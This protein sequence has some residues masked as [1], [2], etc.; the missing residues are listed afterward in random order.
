M[1]KVKDNLDIEKLFQDKFKDFQMDVNPDLWSNI[2]QNISSS[3]TGSAT[4]GATKTILS[5]VI[6]YAAIT[7]GAIVVAA[8]SYYFYDTQS[9]E[10]DKTVEIV[11]TTDL[12]QD[13]NNNEDEIKNIVVID[14]NTDE[15]K[16]N[17]SSDNQ[18]NNNTNNSQVDN[19]DEKTHDNTEKVEETKSNKVEN[20]TNTEEVKEKTEPTTTKT[21]DKTKKT[22]SVVEEPPVV[23]VFPKGEISHRQSTKNPLIYSFN[24]NSE[25][26]VEVKWSF[27]DG[28]FST[29]YNPQHVY[30]K[31]GEYTVTLILKSKDG[32]SII[33][34]S[35]ITIETTS[36]IDEIPNVFT[37][38]GDGNNDEFFIHTKGIVEFSIFIKDAYGNSVFESKDP[39]FKWDGS[40]FSGNM[41]LKGQYY[42]YIVATGDDGAVYSKAGALYIK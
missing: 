42:Y 26:V 3:A 37:P 25:D 1:K 23:K 15:N 12:D 28:N 8:A 10:E 35:K 32:E 6:K 4:V 29:D 27:G 19:H 21:E 30:S 18:T 33:D 17:N 34:K 41:T 5:S 7:T 14:N 2:S 16:Q 11:K 39:D 20:N 13:I 24:S 9:Q 31:A 40:D 36:F 38:N 22:E